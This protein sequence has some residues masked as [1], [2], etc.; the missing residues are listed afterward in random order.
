[1]QATGQSTLQ[2]QNASLLAPFLHEAQTARLFPDSK[3]LVDMPL[4]APPKEVAAAYASLRLPDN[5]E[6]RRAV[7]QQFCRSWMLPVES[8][9]RAVLPQSAAAPPPGWLPHISDPGIRQWAEALRRMWGVLCRE[10]T[11]DVLLHPD[12]HTLLLPA[13][14]CPFVIPGARF[15]EQYYWDSLWS[16]RGMLVCGLVELAQ[17]VV[18]N[19]LGLVEVHGFVPNGMRTYYLN[20]SQPPLLSQMVAALHAATPDDSQ[21]LLRAL[22]ALLREHSYWST[23]PKGVVLRASDGQTHQLSRYW[24]DWSQPRPESYRE[25]VSTAAGLPPAG[26]AALWRELAS[27]AESGWD[28][29]SRWLADGVSLNSCRTTQVVPADL[30][31]FLYQMECNIAA[32]ASELG[33]AELAASFEEHAQRRL[34]AMQAL[35]WDVAG[36]QWRDLVL[37]A[38]GDTQTDAAA[39]GTA[40]ATGAAA[41]AE[42]TATA[43]ATAAA[44]N[45]T[46][47][48]VTSFQQSTV[49]AASNWVPLY[50]GCTPAGSPD[51]ELAV[52]SLQ[53]SGLLQAA[54]VAVSLND[55]GQQ[56]DWPNAWP[57]ITCM[58]VEGCE[59]Y[60]GMAGSKLAAA[61]AQQYLA[62]AHSAWG[63][64]GRNYEKFDSRRQGAAGGGGEYECVDGFGWTNGA[65][66][67]LLQRYGWRP[68][69]ELP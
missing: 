32:F 44:A 50:C 55:T 36:G 39:E 1:M 34:A 69:K 53:A 13:R 7:L 40:V 49:V 2:L 21:L 60:G 35:M 66:L 62:T 29:S 5:E 51:A 47:S 6:Q 9:L 38:H 61:L 14:P 63:Q 46:C 68:A 67:V 42:I 3:T 33:Q 25:D 4:A 64:S 45:E 12:R 26:A 28:F 41:P 54:G 56:W 22:P 24:A 17:G 23:A 11:P 18:S 65:A 59:A 30:N 58:L 48:A 16:L 57:P 43:A 19:M 27:A 8:D 37:A 15:R 31:A 20:R 10:A 52:T